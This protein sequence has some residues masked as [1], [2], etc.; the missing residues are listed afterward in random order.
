MDHQRTTTQAEKSE[1]EEQ[2]TFPFLETMPQQQV[3]G[4]ESPS[5]EGAHAPFVDHSQ[6]AEQFNYEAR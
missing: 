4:T 2:L 5:W 1:N 6:P 3:P